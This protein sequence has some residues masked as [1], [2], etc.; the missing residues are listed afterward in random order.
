MRHIFALLL[1]SLQ[2]LLQAAGGGY[3]T[4]ADFGYPALSLEP[5]QYLIPAVE[6]EWHIS[7]LAPM[8]ATL[9]GIKGK[10]GNR[11]IVILR[12]PSG[13]NISTAAFSLSDT[14]IEA[15][16]NWLKKNEFIDFATHREG[17]TMA[18]IHSVIPVGKEYHVN[19]IMT[20]GSRHA[21]RTNTQPVNA[22]YARKHATSTYQV[23][24]STLELL[25]S[26]VGKK[27]EGRPALPIATSVDEAQLYATLNDVGIA[28]FYL[29]RRGGA[30]DLAFRHYLAH[31]PELVAQWA[32]HFVFLMAYCDERGMYPPEC[33]EGE[34]TISLT[35]GT[36]GTHATNLCNTNT[37]LAQIRNAWLHNTTYL[38]YVTHLHNVRFGNPSQQKFTT[39]SH[40]G[41]AGVESMLQL[42]DK[43]FNLFGY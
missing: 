25:R 27:S 36:T 26:H 2:P 6:R 3:A 9:Q 15:V 20:D 42:R 29:N 23:T 19:L 43:V 16:S 12:T 41:N 14:D 40:V 37:E 5:Q 31:K 30:A 10:W 38:G 35:H 33:H 13:R 8:R 1:L 22:E 17:S 4:P 34:L 32:Q 18:R 11:A 24:D 21:L 28:V 7:G 39:Q